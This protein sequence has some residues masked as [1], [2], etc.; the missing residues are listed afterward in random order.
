VAGGHRFRQ[1]RASYRHTCGV[2]TSYR[3]ICWGRNAEGELGDG[4]TTPRLKPVWVK[5]GHSFNHVRAGASHTCG[6][7]TA[8]R[9]YCWGWNDFGQLGDGT[10]TRRLVPRAVLGGLSFREMSSGAASTCG[11]TMGGQPYCWGRNQYGELGDGTT[12]QRLRPRAVAT[13]GVPFDHVTLGVFHAC[14]VTTGD[15]AYC[16]GWNFYGQL[17]DGTNTNRTTPVP[18]TSELRFSAVNVGVV[19]THTCGMTTS[20]VV[21][22]W[23][24]NGSGNL[25]DGTQIERRT[26]VRVADQM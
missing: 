26:P 13:G 21:Y 5:G 3:A 15:R 24:R 1:L 6:L 4:T 2:T 9:V 23:G 16:W 14:G 22:C 7:S 17:G 12:I 25:G 20:R 18:V 8:G 11:V 19:G 10:T